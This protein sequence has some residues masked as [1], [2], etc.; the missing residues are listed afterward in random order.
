MFHTHYAFVAL[1]MNEFKNVFIIHLTRARLFAARVIAYLDISYFI[2]CSFQ[3][4]DDVAFI[5]LHVVHI[6][7][8]LTG[9]TVQRF[10]YGIRLI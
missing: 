6:E 8:K 3:V 10:A 2:L 4:A 5:A 9:R 1:L 7:E